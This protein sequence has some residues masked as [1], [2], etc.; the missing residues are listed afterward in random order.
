MI[1][2]AETSARK[3][4]N[5][6]STVRSGRRRLPPRGGS[7]AKRRDGRMTKLL[8]G[9]VALITGAGRGIG[10][11]LALLYAAE[12]AKVVVN[13]LG[14]SGSGEG[15]DK[16]PAQEVAPSPTARRPTRW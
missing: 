3:L 6:P 14:G 2:A 1:E 5:F 7:G 8:A 12:G 16:A 11:D 4:L 15:E 9:K 13:D 10:R